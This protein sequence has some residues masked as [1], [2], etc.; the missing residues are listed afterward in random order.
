MRRSPSF[1]VL[2]EAQQPADRY[3][4]VCVLL[5]PDE[6]VVWLHGDIDAAV[7]DELD[8]AVTD[9]TQA[10]LPV[11]VDASNMTFCDSTAVHFL[12][13]LLRSG[14]SVRV[15]D[16][17]GR[18]ARLLELVLAPDTVLERVRTA[19]ADTRRTGS[20]GAPTLVRST[21]SVTS[22]P[23]TPASASAATPEVAAFAARVVQLRRARR[24][25]QRLRAARPR[26]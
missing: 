20:L 26:P 16:P 13:H 18:L 25:A 22:L 10:E 19:L 6:A 4:E 15:E 7:K 21:S 24:R 11:R 9:L 5:D 12:A 17:S 3:G 2:P 23:A 14:L 1:P 8:G